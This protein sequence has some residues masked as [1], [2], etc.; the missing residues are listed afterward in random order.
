MPLQGLATGAVLDIDY[1]ISPSELFSRVF[2]KCVA[3]YESPFRK[4]RSFAADC[5]FQIPAFEVLLVPSDAN[6]VDKITPINFQ[7]HSS[8]HCY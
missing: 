3:D 2:T 1:S 8:D 5:D 4:W 7:R 6:L